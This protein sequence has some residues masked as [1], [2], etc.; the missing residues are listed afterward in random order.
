M[1]RTTPHREETWL[2]RLTRY[3]LA[4]VATAPIAGRQLAAQSAHE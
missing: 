3:V 4:R 1:S 2:A